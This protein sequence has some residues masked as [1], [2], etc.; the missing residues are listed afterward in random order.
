ME[1]ADDD[2]NVVVKAGAGTGKTYSMI[3]RVAFLCN[4]HKDHI[5]DIA[6]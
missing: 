6:D 2:K 1:H 5:D 4:K 3:S